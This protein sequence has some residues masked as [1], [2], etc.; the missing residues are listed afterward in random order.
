MTDEKR[1]TEA[2]APAGAGTYRQ[3]GLWW[4]AAV[5]LLLSLALIVTAVW[6]RLESRTP[7]RLTGSLATYLTLR[8]GPLSMQPQPEGTGTL[9]SPVDL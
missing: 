4:K 7:E 5:G 9:S 6:V 8:E 2:I 1:D 3:G